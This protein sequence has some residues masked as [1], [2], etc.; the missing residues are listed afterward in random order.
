[1]KKPNLLFWKL[2]FLLLPVFLAVLCLGIGRYP[3]TPDR[4]LRILYLGALG[5]APDTREAAVVLS[6]RL[7]RILLALLVG[8]ALSASGT[9]FQALFSNPLATPDTLG[10]ATGASFGAVLALLLGAE[11]LFLVQCTAFGFGFLA[12]LLT[13]TIG[14]YRQRRSLLMVILGGLVISSL[15]NALISLVKY[16]ADPEE[17]LPTISY[18]LMGSLS[19]ARPRS[20]MFSLPFFFLGAAGLFFLRWRLNLLTLPREEAETFGISVPRLRSLTIFFA[21]MLTAAS[22][23]LSGQVGW[24]GLLMPHACR[25]LFGADHRRVLP[26]SMLLGSSFLLV[27]DTLCRSLSSAELPCSILT[28]LLGA[29]IFILLLRKTGGA[30][31]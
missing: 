13:M 24:V 23:S 8:A 16:L 6:I 10:V 2:L 4:V 12:L 25:F 7:P 15:F 18:W 31:L 11:N 14:R 28:A 9:S 1:M 3:L 19:R 29:P 5:Q 26:F 22:V 17:E 21:T 27:V 30:R 20:L